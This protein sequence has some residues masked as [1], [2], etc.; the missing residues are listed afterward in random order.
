MTS[1]IANMEDS[2][3]RVTTTVSELAKQQSIRST[4]QS[5]TSVVNIA[6]VNNKKKWPGLVTVVIFVLAF[7]IFAVF[8]IVAAKYPLSGLLTTLIVIGATLAVL[9]LTYLLLPFLKGTYK[10][11]HCLSLLLIVAQEEDR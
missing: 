1:K 7:V 6:S 11:R 9:L 4:A 10:A 3:G 8:T 5:Q 2:K